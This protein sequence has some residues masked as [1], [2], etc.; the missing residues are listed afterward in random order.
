MVESA[1]V[2]SGDNR[3]ET[4]V[5]RARLGGVAFD[6]HVATRHIAVRNVSQQ[7]LQQV[8]FADGDDVIGRSA[9][10]EWAP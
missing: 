5:N 10:N 3:A 6:V 1:K 4:I 2:W 7:R 9:A 8:P